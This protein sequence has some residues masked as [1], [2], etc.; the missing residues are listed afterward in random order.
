MQIQYNNISSLSSGGSKLPNYDPLDSLDGMTPNT[1]PNPIGGPISSQMEPVADL[2]G[3]VEQALND[4]Y[5]EGL[6]DYYPEDVVY[7]DSDSEVP[8]NTNDG[9]ICPDGCTSFYSPEKDEWG[10]EC[11]DDPLIDGVPP[12]S[13]NAM[14]PYLYLLPLLLLIK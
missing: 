1:A 5:N 9:D 13:K 14:P 7:N 10:C 2:G 8:L 11:S 12:P 6:A 3:S 4:I